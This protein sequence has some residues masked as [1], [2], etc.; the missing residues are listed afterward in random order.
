MPHL[1]E[2]Q[3]EQRQF[4]GTTW[5]QYKDSCRSTTFFPFPIFPSVNGHKLILYEI[6]VKTKYTLTSDFKLHLCVIQ[7]FFS[8][9]VV[10]GAGVGASVLVC[11]VFQDETEVSSF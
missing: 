8:L 10:D 2:S 9:L 6:Q 3:S 1:T 4:D 11:G 7:D 5:S